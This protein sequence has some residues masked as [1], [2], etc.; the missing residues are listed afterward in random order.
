[1]EEAS[2]SLWKKIGLGMFGLGLWQ[3]LGL[4]LR[5]KL[6]QKLR[7]RLWQKLR[8][9][10]GQKLRQKLGQK[11]RDG[12]NVNHDRLV[13]VRMANDAQPTKAKLDPSTPHNAREESP[14][15]IVRL[16]NA[17]PHAR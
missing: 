12:A 10:L 2:I 4:G 11:L 8:Q 1:M 15:D 13:V 6:R 16:Q 14:I 17:Q 9:K 3:K 5:Q 7:Q